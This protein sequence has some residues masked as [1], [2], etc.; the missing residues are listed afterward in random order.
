MTAST[1]IDMEKAKPVAQTLRTSE[2]LETLYCGSK[3]HYFL[4]VEYLALVP[5][6]TPQKGIKPL[7]AEEKDEWLKRPDVVHVRDA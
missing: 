6:N 7:S 3:G 1:E 2:P 5:K 4:V